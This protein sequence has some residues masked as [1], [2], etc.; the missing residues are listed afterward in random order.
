[1]KSIRQ[2]FPIA[3]QLAHY[4]Q[5]KCINDV[6]AAVIVTVMLIPQSLAYAM[7]AGLA[8]HYGLYASI[9]PVVVYSLLGS[10]T[11][12]SVG[13][14]AIASIMT[15][16]ALSSVVATGMVSYVD[17]A[18]TLALLSGTMLLVMGLLRWG[19]I[20][21]FL[22]HTVV[23]GFI[24]ASSLIIALSQVQ[25]LL[26][27]SLHNE[28]FVEMFAA[29]LAVIFAE[30]VRVA[31][32]DF[33][34]TFELTADSMHWLTS[35]VG[36]GTLLFLLAARRYACSVLQYCGMSAFWAASVARMS[37]ILAVITTAALVAGLELDALGVAIVGEVPAG[38]AEPVLPSVSVAALE[39]LAL[40]AFFIAIVGYVE[41]ISVGR[42]LG[43]KRNE[44]IDANQELIGLGGA[45]IAAGCVGAFPVTGGFS[46]S[47]VNFDAGAQTQLAGIFT[48]LGIALTSWLLTPYLYYLPVAMLAATI[49]VAVL[50][51]VDLRTLKHTWHYA[52]SDF[53]AVFITLVITLV[54][55]IEA[56]VAS[57][58]A[59]SIVLHLY[60]TSR[61]HIAEIGL[62][63]QS[64]SFRNI[65][66]FHVEQAAHVLSLRV[67]ESLLFSNAG[68][69]AND[70]QRRVND[71]N[72]IQHLVL[73]C[74]AINT[75]DFS[76]MEML[77]E[78]NQWLLRKGVRLHL[79]DVKVPVKALLQKDNFI[80]ALSGCLFMTHLQAHQQLAKSWK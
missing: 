60:H 18:I 57:G 49:I 24:T 28:S 40:P 30:L 62:E 27:L 20:A 37:P 12:L 43:A 1:M 39:A 73:H 71:R 8:P 14:V 54:A 69:L 7:L 70:I 42:T 63:P 16:S 34:F 52:K 11:A 66:H 36:I 6:I 55:G 45:N 46:R 75:I 76:A 51:L 72:D 65:R 67:D 68:Y 79:S 59:T 26:G 21:N 77:H 3:T 44:N 22:S 64:Q 56:G 35:A 25:H 31:G 5:Q 4:N 78:L 32:Q 48:A 23:S 33:V 80:D 74:G 47:V 50:S 41:S 58:I 9:V 61:P 17:G 10:S 29:L 38:I 15:A 2:Y 13:P 53:A 19:A